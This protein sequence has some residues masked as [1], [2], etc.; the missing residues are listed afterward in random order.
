MPVSGKGQSPLR[1]A[2]AHRTRLVRK[3]WP[4]LYRS[5]RTPGGPTTGATV[6]D[7]WFLGQAGAGG[8]TITITRASFQVT[9][10]SFSLH[11]TLLLAAAQF[12]WNERPVS[13]GETIA[14]GRAAFQWAA[15]GFLLNETFRITRAAFSLTGK[16]AYI[17]DAFSIAKAAFSWS[18]RG[19]SLPESL[20]IGRAPF[21]FLAKPFT[22]QEGSAAAAVVNRLTSLRRLLGRR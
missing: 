22:L 11:Q 8:E 9:A 21:K 20:V 15:R 3:Q 14:V 12:Q 7:D 1:S 18:T 5:T 2:W 19:F 4:A 6:W 13:A 17:S 10:R 16:A